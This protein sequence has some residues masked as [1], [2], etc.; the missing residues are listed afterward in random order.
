MM[1][2]TSAWL[3]IHYRKRF[4]TFRFVVIVGTLL[5]FSISDV[6]TI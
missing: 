5:F 6:Y 4:K 1:L 3:G 2:I